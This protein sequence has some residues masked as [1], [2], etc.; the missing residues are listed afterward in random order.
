MPEY[1]AIQQ[2]KKK[3]YLNRIF[4]EINKSGKV[5]NKIQCTI[6]SFVRS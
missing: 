6:R 3:K 1:K 4:I 5:N 2:Y